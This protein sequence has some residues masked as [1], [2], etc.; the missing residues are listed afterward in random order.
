M[1]WP[2]SSGEP[3]ISDRVHESVKRS[4]RQ[5]HAIRELRGGVAET[6]EKA[7]VIRERNHFGE[8]LT[9]AMGGTRS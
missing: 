9:I 5:A 1:I 3:V 4:E 7:R 2:F 8:S 6:A